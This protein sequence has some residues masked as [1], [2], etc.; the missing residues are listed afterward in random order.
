MPDCDWG[1]VSIIG[2]LVPE[3]PPMPPAT[4]IRNAL[5]RDEGGSG[6]PI[7]PDAYD[8]AVTFW[9]THAAVR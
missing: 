5:G 8:L 1:I 9:D 7:D 6:R 4:Q 2:T 3:E